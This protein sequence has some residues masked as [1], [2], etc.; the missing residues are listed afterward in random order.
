MGFATRISYYIFDSTTGLPVTGK[1]N[2]TDYTSLKVCEDGTLGADIKASATIV[3]DGAGNYGFALTTA[4]TPVKEVKACA[5][6]ATSTLV[7][8]PV[9]IGAD[10]LRQLAG[11]AVV[12]DS[13]ASVNQLLNGLV[14]VASSVNDAGASTT[15]FVT[16]LS[17]SVTD[18]YKGQAIVFTNGALQGQLGQIKGYNGSTK[19]VTL[20]SALTSAPV[21][22]VTFVIVN[23][24]ASRKMADWLGTAIGTDNKNLVSSDAQDLS[25]TLAV[26]AKT[27]NGATPNNL[28]AG[29]KMDLQDAPNSTAIAAFKTGLA[30]TKMDLQDAPN[31]TA[32][33]AFK[34]GL[35]DLN[36]A[37]HKILGAT[38]TETSSSNLANSFKNFFDLANPTGNINSLPS[39]PPNSGSGLP[40][41][42]GGLKLPETPNTSTKLGTIETVANKLDA[43]IE[44]V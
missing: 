14:P 3:D 7:A 35:A 10:S 33:A 18:F 15:V 30:G 38:L 17:S 31:A 23:V 37:L 28:A 24:A 5:V 40:L 6:M 9:V 39:A 42:D 2:S 26:N 19:A 34:T 32:I 21:N 16:A 41:L 8:V 1:T 44:A 22:G 4:T 29:A 43:M 11:T 12:T 25:S 27:L 20:Q 36:V 13:L